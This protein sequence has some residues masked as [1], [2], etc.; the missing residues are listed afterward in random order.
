MK[1]FYLLFFTLLACNYQAPEKPTKP[2][3]DVKPI[4]GQIVFLKEK[5]KVNEVEA[6]LGRNL[7]QADKITTENK[8]FVKMEM[9]D[10]TSINLR[11][12]SQMVL[13]EYQLNPS[14]R[15]V[16]MDLVIGTVKTLFREKLTSKQPGYLK[17]KTGTVSFGVRG[18]EFITQV[19]KNK[20]TKV[21]LIEG[22]IAMS[23]PKN[24]DN[25]D[26][27]EVQEIKPLEM[28]TVDENLVVSQETVSPAQLN[29]TDEDTELN[30]NTLPSKEEAEGL[31][32][33]D[34]S[35]PKIKQDETSSSYLLNLEHKNQAVVLE[36][37]NNTFYFKGT[38]IVYNPKEN[39]DYR[40]PALTT[41]GKK[42]YLPVSQKT[43]NQLLTQKPATSGSRSRGL[44]SEE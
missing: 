29:F 31:E 19:E 39:G 4:I 2:S 34:V 28:V 5:V 32:L 10:K 25:L 37:K 17:V 12:N 7:Y 35:P 8:S 16:V 27:Q 43:L 24:K 42:V 36:E 6:S 40:I 21:L 33:L 20:K 44:A 23:K 18:T 3:L 41:Q 26:F 1:I 9:K 15:K 22:S 38:T 13:T 14:E 30:L 11:A